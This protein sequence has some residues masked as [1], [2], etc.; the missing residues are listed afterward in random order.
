[1]HGLLSACLS[2]WYVGAFLHDARDAMIVTVQ[3][4]LFELV[5]TAAAARHI[6]DDAFA[7]VLRV[8]QPLYERGHR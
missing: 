1:M 6:D 5:T 3:Q 4:N 8:S 7:S 2:D